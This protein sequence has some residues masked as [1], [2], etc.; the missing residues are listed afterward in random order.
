MHRLDPRTKLAC[1][2]LFMVA[3]F[4]ISNVVTIILFLLVV[5]LHFPLAKL[6]IRHFWGN[7][8]VFFWLYA[9]TFS[10][11]LFFHPGNALF[12]L[13]WLGWEVTAEGIAAGVLF[14][15]RISVLISL[16]FILMAVTT[17]QDL[18]DALG[19]LLAPLERLRIPISEVALMLSITLRFLPILMQEAFK[20][21]RAQIARG[22]DLE[23]SWIGRIKKSLP[24]ILPLFSGALKKADDLAVALEAR[25]YRGAEGRTRLVELRV[26]HRDYIA[27]ASTSVL[28]IAFFM[29]R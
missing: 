22:A 5:L 21:Q 8:K 2:F 26:R 10:L 14:T 23:G 13:P 7:V 3:V 29:F 6:P 27:L 9:I 16:S 28:L 19:R 25:G 1:W 24:M 18:T 4:V 20:I 11:H 12:Q 17:P 15:V